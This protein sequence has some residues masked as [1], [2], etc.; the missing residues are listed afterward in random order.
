MSPTY[1]P[2]E[3]QQR[4]EEI[5]NQGREKYDHVKID[6]VNPSDPNSRV[7]VLARRHDDHTQWDEV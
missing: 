3:A 6:R 2:E 1:S 4:R 7:H 5:L